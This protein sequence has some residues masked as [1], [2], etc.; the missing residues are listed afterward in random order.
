MLKRIKG[1]IISKGIGEGRAVVTAQPLSFLG[2]V[3][4]ER[5]VIM[6][7]T[8]ELYG[9]SIVGS[10]LTFP[11]GKGSTVGSYVMYELKR[12]GKAPAA[13]INASSETIVAVGAIISNIPLID[14]LDVDPIAAIKP[15]SHVLVNCVDGFIEVEN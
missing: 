15:G 2:G 7:L 6:D 13:I 3:D 10:V 8:H 14:R 12:N 9:V 11:Q 1:R 5:G 4:P